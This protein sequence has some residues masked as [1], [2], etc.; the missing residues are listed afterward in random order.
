MAQ[1]RYEQADESG[2]GHDP[3]SPRMPARMPGPPLISVIVPTKHEE[4]LLQGCLEQFTPQ[5]RA[6]YRL[7]LIVSDGGSTDNTVG[8]AA[9]YADYIAVHEEPYRQTIA[10]GRNRG[11]ALANSE[12]FIFV[13]ADTRFDNIE[14]F[15]DRAVQRFEMDPSLSALACKVEVAEE[16]RQLSD[17]L[18]H[19]MFNRYVWI[20]NRFIGMGRGECQLVRRSAFKA[21]GGYNPEMVAGE[22]FDL[23]HRL[24]SVGRVKYD[25][26]LLVLESP[27]RY[28]KYG[29]MRVWYDW[30]RN[31]FAVM[32]KNKSVSDVWEEVR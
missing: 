20:V 8:I 3:R 31:G 26:K 24:Q 15:L 4:K 29:Y 21:I 18:F 13:N 2:I 1:R 12:L 10:E 32:F 11:A 27:R 14:Q 23:F 9:A 19:G 6:R 22:D 30:C 16:E 28:R 25:P 17:V 7:E 5:I